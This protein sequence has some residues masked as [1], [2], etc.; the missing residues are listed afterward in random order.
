MRKVSFIIFLFISFILALFV[1]YSIVNKDN[2]E[3]I[4]DRIELLS[5][6]FAGI[7]S[8]VSFLTL[9]IT[10]TY[11]NK[12]II[13]SKNFESIL[14]PYGLSLEEI[15]QSFYNYKKATLNDKQL[16][17]LYRIFI[18]VSCSSV[19]TWGV[20]IGIYTKFNFV[21]KFPIDIVT[22]VNITLVI[23]W[24][25]LFILLVYIG[26]AIRRVVM[27]IDPNT[28]KRLPIA[29]KV[30]NFDFLE[31]NNA[32]F[33]EFFLKNTPILEFYRNPAVIREK[34][35]TYECSFCL[36]IKVENFRFVLNLYHKNEEQIELLFKCFGETKK[37]DHIG[38]NIYI[39]LT[40]ELEES[41]YNELN[42][43]SE[44]MGEIK[45]YNKELKIVSR[46]KL[47]KVKEDESG[48]KIIPYRTIE[49]ERNDI[50]S[51]IFLE[52]SSDY[53]EYRLK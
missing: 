6:L 31:K 40:N 21:I 23:F 19:F 48:F 38:E 3:Y 9:F 17:F 52:C 35:Y 39:L 14:H 24:V 7:M 15:R 20:A 22:V 13:A 47:K 37:V 53:A 44:I 26:D 32:N 29:T 28:D 2:F 1:D 10:F 34:S 42:Q 11:D 43:T 33:D 30:C 16:K 49:K 8:L 41:I 18:F 27:Q 50:D 12:L 51:G 46:L 25:S 45:I 36:P 5:W 4:K